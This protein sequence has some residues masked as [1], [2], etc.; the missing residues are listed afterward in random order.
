MAIASKIDEIIHLSNDESQL[1]FNQLKMKVKKIS[2]IS[3]Q[4]KGIDGIRILVE[5]HKELENS[6]L[7]FIESF[8]TDTV[9]AWICAGWNNS[10]TTDEGKEKLCKYIEKLKSNGTELTKTAAENAL[11]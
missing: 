6:L 5:H 1:V 10:I 3:T 4:P 8:Q 11:K 7:S 2:D 9:G